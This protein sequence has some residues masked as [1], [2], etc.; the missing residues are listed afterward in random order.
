MLIT[1]TYQLRL[2]A[3]QAIIKTGK[4]LGMSPVN[5]YKL[6]RNLNLVCDADCYL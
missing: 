1:N 2:C 4:V 5:S 6:A 3:A